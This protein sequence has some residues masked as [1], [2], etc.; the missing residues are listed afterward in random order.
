MK[1]CKNCNMTL[2][3]DEFYVA[4]RHAETGKTYYASDCKSCAKVRIA[5]SNRN[6]DRS[7]TNRKSALKTKYGLTLEDVDA[8]YIAQDGCCEICRNATKLS[9]L[10]VDHC[11]ETGTIRGLLCHKCNVG[12][13]H[14]NDNIEFLTRAIQYLK[15][16]QHGSN[17]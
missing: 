12:L 11:H 2:H 1:T 4:G 17:D 9:D 15:E 13:G 7:L 8:M 10:R 5:E 6:N 14:F 3:H 16:A